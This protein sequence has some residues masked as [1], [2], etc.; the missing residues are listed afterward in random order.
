MKLIDA[1]KVV[2]K[3]HE[4]SIADAWGMLVNIKTN[5]PFAHWAGCWV[6]DSGTMLNSAGGEIVLHTESS[7]YKKL[8]FNRGIILPNSYYF[9]SQFHFS[10]HDLEGMVFKCILRGEC[11]GFAKIIKGHIIEMTPNRGYASIDIKHL[12]NLQVIKESQ[13]EK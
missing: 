2:F 9:D 12:D 4:H 10:G 7:I 6:K 5:E 13:G 3:V 8:L 1:T 11:I